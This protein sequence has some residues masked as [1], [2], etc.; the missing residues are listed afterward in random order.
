[1]E[2]EAEVAVAVE[3][4]IMMG[5]GGEGVGRPRETRSSQR[6]WQDCTAQRRGGHPRS[7]PPG[8]LSPM[9]H[10]QCESDSVIV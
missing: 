5:E 4:D 10:L 2:V 6:G 8:C 1:M 7:D 3:C 9:K